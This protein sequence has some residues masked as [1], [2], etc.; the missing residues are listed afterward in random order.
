[1]PRSVFGFKI[2]GLIPASQPQFATAA[3][4]M[5]SKEVAK[6]DLEQKLTSPAQ[7]EKI[8]PVIEE[9]IDDFLRVKIKKEMPVVGAFIGDKTI[10]S[11]KKV[12]VAELQSLFPVVIG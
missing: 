10:G 6:M 11:L 1:M 2:Q 9:K 5:V 7:V 8:M 12:F 3:A 4:L